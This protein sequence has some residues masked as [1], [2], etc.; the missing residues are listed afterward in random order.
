[1]KVDNR[2]F[3]VVLKDGSLFKVPPNGTIRNLPLCSTLAYA[4]IS[5][6]CWSGPLPPPTVLAQ[7]ALH[8]P[9]PIE[10][11]LVEMA[12]I[13]SELILISIPWKKDLYKT[14][15]KSLI[16]RWERTAQHV[17]ASLLGEPSVVA[18]TVDQA[19]DQAAQPTSPVD[20]ANC[21]S[22]PESNPPIAVPNANVT[23]EDEAEV[24]EG[25]EPIASSPASSR[26]V[27]SL[28]DTDGGEGWSTGRPSDAY[29][30]ISQGRFIVYSPPDNHYRLCVTD[31][32]FKDLVV[33]MSPFK[34]ATCRLKSPNHVFCIVGDTDLYSHLFKVMAYPPHGFA[35]LKS[36]SYLLPS[37]NFD[38]I[39]DHHPYW[40]KAGDVEVR[41]GGE[42]RT[43]SRCSAARNPRSLRTG[44]PLLFEHCIDSG[45][46]QFSKC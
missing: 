5:H 37:S 27:Q 40:K 11:N 39:L 8:A 17:T 15:R 29:Q 18:P 16:K 42:S 1:M 30:R 31:L 28:S 25:L 35:K 6:K 38:N 41:Y 3:S 12:S 45:F 22:G 4:Y 24:S 13:K 14:F 33:E 36:V 19:P 10:A 20:D 34:A 23:I 43:V 2:R 26:L 46:R 7:A 44:F 32:E 21:T 9:V